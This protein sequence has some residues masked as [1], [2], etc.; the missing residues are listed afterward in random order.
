LAGDV[1]AVPA[2]INHLERILRSTDL[3]HARS[4]YRS[5]FNLTGVRD[6]RGTAAWREWWRLNGKARIDVQRDPG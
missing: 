6:L 1:R 2:L 3:S 4:A 5:L